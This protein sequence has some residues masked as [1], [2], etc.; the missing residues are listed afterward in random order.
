MSK[1]PQ[2]LSSPSAPQIHPISGG[3]DQFASP[4]AVLH[5]IGRVTGHLSAKRRPSDAVRRAA[6][7]AVSAIGEIARDVEAQFGSELWEVEI[8]HDAPEIGRRAGGS[9]GEMEE[10][11]ALL[12]D[13]G[14]LIS[15]TA[16]GE[17]RLRLS[18]E[19][20]GEHPTLA[21]IG[22]ETARTLLDGVN[23]SG[24]PALAVLR[25]IGVCSGNR[26][27]GDTGPWVEVSLPRLM[28]STLFRRTAVSKALAD[29]EHARLI[30]RAL[31]AGRE[32]GCRL[33]P[34]AFGDADLAPR[35]PV[36]PVAAPA[37]SLPRGVPS[38]DAAA[39]PG[40]DSPTVTLRF[41]GSEVRIHGGV[42]CD[43]RPGPNGVPVVEIRPTPA[44]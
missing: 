26:T 44:A 8:P 41:G 37:V 5:A 27:K 21:R 40:G 19:V 42:T 6:V 24:M 16:G 23:A 39:V 2:A 28:D 12:Q 15:I 18:K 31:R 7:A 25:E 9:A 17:R 29:L 20:F 33:L 14:C 35:L 34:A 11:I 43:V 38:Q 22:W 3:A 10:A 30:G 4:S 36:A 32:H 1:R 13:T